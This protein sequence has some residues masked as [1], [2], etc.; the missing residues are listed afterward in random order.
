M[1]G[2][3]DDAREIEPRARVNRHLVEQASRFVSDRLHGVVRV[4][5]DHPRR[6][7]PTIRDSFSNKPP[8]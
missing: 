4:E 6:L 8:A 2:L 7:T 3:I 5:Y 1:S